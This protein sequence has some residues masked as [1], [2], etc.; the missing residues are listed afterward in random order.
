MA[1]WPKPWGRRHGQRGPRPPTGLAM[2][3][4]GIALATG[5]CIS[6]AEIS[7][8]N[9]IIG[10]REQIRQKDNELVAQRASL[11]EV[12]RQLAIARSIS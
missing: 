12:T 10:L 11:D 7:L 2:G 1:H 8:R 5:G 6:Q 3:M 4:L 9:E